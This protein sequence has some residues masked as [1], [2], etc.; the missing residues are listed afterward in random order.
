M[1]VVWRTYWIGLDDHCSEIK[2]F[3]SFPALHSGMQ[4]LVDRTGCR[5]DQPPPTD[6]QIRMGGTR[7][8]IVV[9]GSGCRAVYPAECTRLPSAPTLSRF[10]L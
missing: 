6:S 10:C 7:T 2:L 1:A 8:L 5:H 4:R 3:F 9:G